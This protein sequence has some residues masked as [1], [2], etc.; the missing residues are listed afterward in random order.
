MESVSFFADTEIIE[1]E[2]KALKEGVDSLSSVETT[3]QCESPAQDR[4]R[5]HALP[6]RNWSCR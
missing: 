1:L 6:S 5:E 3:L 4:D 2:E